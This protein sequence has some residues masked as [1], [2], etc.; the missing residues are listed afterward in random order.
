MSI[1]VFAPFGGLPVPLL[2]LSRVVLIPVVA[3]VAYEGIRGL[4]KV[5]RTPPGRIALIPILATQRLTTREP[6]DR[7]IE[8]AIEALSLAR[9]GDVGA[10]PTPLSL[11]S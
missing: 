2:V 10:P 6:D 5:R 9:A 1:V 3:A 7:Q 4:A 8:V 11:A